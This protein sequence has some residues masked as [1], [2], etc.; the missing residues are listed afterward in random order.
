MSAELTLYL[1]GRSPL[2]RALRRSAARAGAG[3]SL[4]ADGSEPSLSCVPDLGPSGGV[5]VACD[6]ELA[7]AIAG[8]ALGMLLECCHPPPACMDGLVLSPAA[9]VC[10]PAAAGPV[11]AVRVRGVR[12]LA[13]HGPGA[14]AVITMLQ[15]QHTR[16]WVLS[17]TL[18]SPSGTPPRLVGSPHVTVLEA[19]VAQD[20]ARATQYMHDR[21]LGE[22]WPGLLLLGAPHS[23]AD[24]ALK[25]LAIFTEAG[26]ADELVDRALNAGG[27]R[28]AATARG[29]RG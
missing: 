6:D 17:A 13:G 26:Y 10:G 9:G 28:T 4:E 29:G 2:E 14:P 19:V 22:D 18:R 7:W 8:H 3:L 11:D 15:V 12:E 23:S 16:C 20:T 1:R 24:G 27:S 25:L 5:A 21:G